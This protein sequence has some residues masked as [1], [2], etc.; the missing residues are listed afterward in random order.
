[1]KE[2]RLNV[3]IVEDDEAH[4]ELISRSLMDKDDNFITKIVPTIE[5]AKSEINNFKP[6][7]LIT[8]WRLPDGEG[9]EILK[10]SGKMDFPVIIMTSYGNEILAV[11]AIK[12][13]AIDYVVKSSDTLSD[14]YR[15]VTRVLREWE[16]IVRR[17]MAEEALK[18]S[19]SLYRTTIE[20]IKDFVHVVD[21]DLRLVLFNQAFRNEIPHMDGELKGKYLFEVAPALPDTI[22]NEYKQVINTGKPLITVDEIKFSSTDLWTETRKFPIFDTRGQVC[23]VLTIIRDITETKKAE[24]ERKKLEAQLLHTQKLESLG[25]LAG[26][27][28]HDFN[29]ILMAILGNTDLAMMDISSSSPARDRLLDIEKSSRRA[30]ELCRQMLAYSGKGKFII[31]PINLNNIL[32]EMAHMFEISVSKKAV[33]KYNLC[34]DIKPVE[35]DA[36]QIRQVIMNLIINASEAIGDQSGFISVST[37]SI[38]CDRAY[39]NETYLDDNLPEGLYSYIEVC[40]TGCGMDRESQT[41]IFDPFFTTKFTGRGLGLAAV[42]GIVR[43]HRGA[44]KLFS[45]PGKGTRFRV[46]FPVT[47]NSIEQSKKKK[48]KPLQYRGKG[49][50]L[51]VDDEYTIL[52]VL[53][54]MLVSHGFNVLYASDGIEAIEIFRKY[55]SPSSCNKIVCVIMDLTMPKKDGIETFLEMKLLKKNIPVI[56]SSGYNEQEL[57]KKYSGT[58]LAGFLQKP[59]D[60]ELLISKLTELLNK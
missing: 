47:K 40:D 7:V 11:E 43:G 32:K 57:E 13:G 38:E 15:I 51:I 60:M 52:E 23:Q 42:L 26:G 30:A 59:Y 1:M 36:T 28:A 48:K 18:E 34:K 16:H 39:L 35:G 4:G 3:L 53:D 9:I 2:D 25:I 50:I 37:G 10:V 17:R 21:L 20:A 58:G 29:N 46:L 33:L 49:T 12:A 27:I 55:S 24:E 56:L 45:E 22:K 8:D 54:R 41:R 31:E 6:N 19:E 5:Q 44:I 14:M